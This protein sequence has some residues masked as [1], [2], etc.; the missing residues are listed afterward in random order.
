M[1]G[2]DPDPNQEESELIETDI[3]VKM[4]LFT[5]DENVPTLHD[6]DN[7]EYALTPLCNGIFH[8]ERIDPTSETFSEHLKMVSQ[9]TFFLNLHFQN[10]S[11]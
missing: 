1:D 4:H 11:D 10:H 6:Q 7:K 8:S 5:Y 2:A 9:H 3:P